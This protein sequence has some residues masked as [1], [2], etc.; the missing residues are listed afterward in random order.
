VA[1]KAEES[2]PQFKRRAYN[3]GNRSENR[4]TEHTMK[5]HGN[6]ISRRRATSAPCQESLK[7]A[8]ISLVVVIMSTS[9]R[10]PR[11]ALRIQ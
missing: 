10:A 1:L 5:G 11:R 6:G 3:M 2:A 8:T 4:V 7:K 9:I